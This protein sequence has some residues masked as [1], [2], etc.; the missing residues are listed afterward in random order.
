MDTTTIITSTEPLNGVDVYELVKT[1]STPDS[2]GEPTMADQARIVQVPFVEPFH[3]KSSVRQNLL[4][5]KGLVE[6]KEQERFQ[7]D[8]FADVDR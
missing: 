1:V 8:S 5:F 4:I 3:I 7:G 6:C 2:T